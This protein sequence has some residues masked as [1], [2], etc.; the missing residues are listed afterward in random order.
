MLFLDI[1]ECQF[2]IEYSRSKKL[3][4]YRLET[5]IYIKTKVIPNLINDAGH[6]N[7]IIYLITKN[8]TIIIKLWNL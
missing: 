2:F 5:S 8:Y 3:N 6:C 1:K 4:N 7:D